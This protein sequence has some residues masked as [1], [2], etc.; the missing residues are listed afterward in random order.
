MTILEAKER[1]VMP[2]LAILCDLTLT[3]GSILHWSTL[4][5]SYE[6][7]HYSARISDER[8]MYWRLTGDLTNDGS[9][10]YSLS[11]GDADGQVSAMNRAGLLRGA[12]AKV[13]LGVCEAG[14]ISDRSALVAGIVDNYSETDSRTMKISLTNRLNASR[15]HF[16]PMRI[17]KRCSW[18]FPKNSLERELALSS[19][20]DG[21]YSTL[22]RCG[23]SADL[24]G[25]VGNL[26]NGVPFTG[27]DFTRTSCEERGMFSSDSLGRPTRRFSGIEFIPASILVRGH[28]ESV[29]RL[30][31]IVSLDARFNDVIPAVY[32]TGW[33][34]APVVFSRNDGNLTF[35]EVL[36]GLGEIDRVIKVLVNGYEVPLAV[37]GRN[38]TGTGWHRLVSKGNR[39][40]VFNGEF[41]LSNG[42]PAGD[43]Y[44]SLALLSVVVPNIISQGKSS[45][46]VEVLLGGI[47]VPVLGEDG[48]LESFDLSSNPAW[49]I[50]DILRRAGWKLD[51]LDL[52]SFRQTAAYCDET[53]PAKDANGN[54]VNVPRFSVNLVLKRRYSVGEL[55]RGIRLA[56]QI[57]LHLNRDGQIAVRP[58]STVRIE[59]PNKPEGSNSVASLNLGW[60]AYDFG[61]G[62]NGSSGILVNDQNDAQ[63]LMY[64]K[65]GVDSANRVGFEIQDSLNEFRQDSISVVDSVD[66][67]ARRL[68][69]A[70][71][72]P[73]MGVPNFPQSLR[74]CQTWL[75]RSIEGNVFVKFSTTM[76]GI[77]LRPGDLISI[78]Y[79]KYGL[80]RALFRVQEVLLSSSLQLIEVSCQ[81]H[82]DE[83][84]SDDALIRYSSSRIHAWGN[85]SV[86]AV[87]GTKVE[88][89]EVSFDVRERLSLDADGRERAELTIPFVRPSASAAKSLNAPIVS[90][91]F[92]VASVGGNLKSGSYFYGITAVDATGAES[93]LSSLVQVKVESLT[94][95]NTVTIHGISSPSGATALNLYRGQSPRSLLRVGSNL[96]VA[97]DLS[98]NG[99]AIAPMLAPDDR[100]ISLR[101]YW[102]KELLGSTASSMWSNMSIGN[103]QLT[104]RPAEWVGKRVV[105]LGG[106]GIGQERI[107]QQNTVTSIEVDKAWDV[108]PGVDSQFCVVDSSW[109]LGESA[110][111]TELKEYLPAWGGDTFQ[112]SLRSVGSD[113]LEMDAIEAP[114][115]RWRLGVGLSNGS[116]DGPPPKPFFGLSLLEGGTLRFGDIAFEDPR[117]VQ[118]VSAALL[119]LYFWD[120]LLA[121]TGVHLVNS[122]EE[123]TTLFT[124]SGLSSTLE[125]DSFVQVGSEIV[126]IV[127]S[128]E[129]SMDY[130]V[131]RACFG[132]AASSHSALSPCFVLNVN[133]TPLTFVPG[134]LNSSAGS[135]FSYPI[136][137]PNVRVACASL[138]L[139]SRLGKSPISD[140]HFMALSDGGLRTLSGGQIV[141]SSQGYL[142]IE[143]AAG[144]TITLDRDTV[145]RDLFAV[146]EEAP[147]GGD[148]A[149]KVRVDGSD[150]AELSI[151]SGQLSS[152]AINRFNFAPIRSG[153]R[154]NFDILSI[155]PSAAGSPGRDL[156]IMV[157]T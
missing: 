83:W 140:I 44:G 95:T 81:I 142:S 3:D 57:Q 66:A 13:F 143:A 19:G 6:S 90:F 144:S 60:T 124:F 148:V 52:V 33:L 129:G 105:I 80:D 29:G 27:C 89:G 108:M 77:H 70:Q 38:M 31:N 99:S 103:T 65:P 26:D 75:S 151:L 2:P 106:K 149:V 117:N 11:I 147:D 4:K 12:F 97:A 5:C 23:Y 28:G 20:E 150:Y 92:T 39:T 74:I 71:S 37:D 50:C 43:P 36:L 9:N 8:A 122:C 135:S 115:I 67:Q 107:I 45:L 46:K 132:S 131:K 86:R 112:L 47:K 64:S 53:V 84:Y 58:E 138:T 154:L 55:L 63:F 134:F 113:G 96:L 54:A 18:S 133:S 7:Q 121:P 73:V 128:T 104:M 110:E 87:C 94:A 76:R 91:N 72:L 79:Q 51:E 22:F 61:D 101:S 82:R 126:A 152:S 111:G 62:T 59:Q 1:S 157:R 139:Y 78:S 21:R 146:V 100:F 118:G 137:L 41:T 49:I 120:E 68:E 32:G 69:V 30:S 93:Q 10:S 141:L 127:S 14:Q 16:P 130:T 42:T 15:T 85:Q 153:S 123:L 56:A 156:S 116:E 155:P 125:V 24:T 98:D 40:G 25:G 35:A 17:Q 119:Q 34:Q 88:S 136:R 48:S 102:R 114:M 145:V 109:R